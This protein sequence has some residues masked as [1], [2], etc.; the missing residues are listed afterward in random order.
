[1]SSVTSSDEE[2][3]KEVEGGLTKPGRAGTLRKNDYIVIKGF[4]CKIIELTTS[5]TGKHGH[6]KAN[7]T[8]VDIFTGKKYEDSQ[9]TSHN[10]DVPFVN[11]GEY[12]LVNLDEEGKITYLEEDGTMN[13][14]LTMDIESDLYKKIL[15]DFQNG[16]D[17]LITIV[18]S[19]G[20][21]QVTDYRKDSSN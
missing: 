4:P 10:V 5:K 13:E 3:H 9:S 19:M 21:S 15:E 6:A 12:D 2:Y 20:I 17:I 14:E 1:M 11:K 8:A 16:N 18:S 7:I